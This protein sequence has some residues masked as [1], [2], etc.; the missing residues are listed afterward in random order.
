MTHSE[1]DGSKVVHEFSVL[2]P[3]GNAIRSD[4]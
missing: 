1:I 4:G 2:G 3:N